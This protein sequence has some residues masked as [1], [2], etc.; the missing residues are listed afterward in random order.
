MVR[1]RLIL[2]SAFVAGFLALLAIDHW[3][4][5]GVLFRLL[6]GAVLVAGLLEFYALTE[7]GGARPLKWLP[8]VLVA[9]FVLAGVVARVGDLSPFEAELGYHASDLTRFY[10]ALGSATAAMLPIVLVAHVLA[11]DPQ[12]WVTDAPATCL[13]LL[14]VWFLGAHALGILGLGVGQM[15]AFIA[16]A[17]LGDS[18][19]WFVGRTWGRRPLAPRVS[20]R[21]TVEGALG[22]LAASVVAAIVLGAALERGVDV[23]YWLVFGLLVGATAQLGDLVESAL[24]RSADVKDSAA[25]LPQFGGVLDLVDSLILSAP[26]AY[27]L[28]VLR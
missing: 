17:K 26:V 21:K 11:R 18:G 8:A 25:L 10:T 23:G 1:T 4:T 7:R 16:T 12:R 15:L 27:W 14:Y 3:K 2:G 19:A 24:K 28:L 5:N 22:G 13:G 20:P 9:L 6:V